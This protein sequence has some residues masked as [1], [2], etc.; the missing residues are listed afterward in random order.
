MDQIRVQILLEP[1]QHKALKQAARQAHKS[2]SELV[3]DITDEY[4]AQVD[5]EQQDDMLLALEQ[6]RQIRER[7]QVFQ[8]DPL[9]EVRAERQDQ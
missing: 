6:L 8:G 1:R 3:R 9:A 7:Q 4:L 5:I 2:L